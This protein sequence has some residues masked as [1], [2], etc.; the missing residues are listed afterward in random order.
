MNKNSLKALKKRT[1]KEQVYKAFNTKSN[2][3][4]VTRDLANCYIKQRDLENDLSDISYANFSAGPI[5]TVSEKIFN[6]LLSENFY[7]SKNLGL[8][9]KSLKEHCYQRKNIGKH[10][11]PNMSDSEI[12]DIVYKYG[13]YTKLTKNEGN[14]KKNINN[15][16]SNWMKLNPNKT[17]VDCY[18]HFGIKLGYINEN[19]K[20]IK[21]NKKQDVYDYCN[22]YG[23][24]Y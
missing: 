12:V 8:R 24:G 18:F 1:T 4:N 19:D 2:R 17:W 15:V 3:F 11:T 20:F 16:I 6:G 22:K 5:K 7:E 21:L 13:H 9:K 23:F 10:F 14:S